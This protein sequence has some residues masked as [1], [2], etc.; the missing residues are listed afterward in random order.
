VYDYMPGKADWLAR[1]LPREGAKAAERRALDFAHDDVV[2]CDLGARVG[3]VRERVGASPYRF[4]FVVAGGGMVLGRLRR[5]ALEGD[6]DA[7]AEDVMEP[8]PSTVRADT[9]AADLL[10]RLTRQ[11]LTSAVVTD[12][13]GRLMGVV[14]RADLEGA[15]PR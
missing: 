3:D 7:R 14:R 12:P 13:E 15:E 6:P 5:A 10:E 8:G 11:D 2:T 4:A 9:P 1:G